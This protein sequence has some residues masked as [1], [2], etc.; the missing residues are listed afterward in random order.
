M[1]PSYLPQ[2]HKGILPQERRFWLSR[3]PI[4]SSDRLVQ[5]VQRAPRAPRQ[6]WSEGTSQSEGQIFCGK[7]PIPVQIVDSISQKAKTFSPLH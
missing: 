3:L 1:R 5:R 6:N 7:I 2:D 4:C